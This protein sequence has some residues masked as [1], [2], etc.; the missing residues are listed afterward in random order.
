MPKMH[1]RRRSF[2]IFLALLAAGATAFVW[3]RM[4]PLDVEVAQP[5]HG[6]AIDA[7]YATGIVEP[8]IAVPIVPRVAGRMVERLV[9]EGMRVRKG[10]VLARLEAPDLGAAQDELDARARFAHRALE[11]AATL[12]E[13]GLGSVAAHDQAFAD[14]QAAD[15]AAAR[16]RELMGFMTLMA[17]ADGTIM[18]RDGEVGQ[19]IAINQPIFQLATDAP[20][21]ITADVDEE[22]IADVAVGLPV[23]IHAD[24]FPDAVFDGKVAEVTPMGDPATRS[25]RVRIHFGSETPLRVG[26]TTETNIVVRHHESALLVPSS[27]LIGGHVWVVHGGRLERRAVRVGIEGEKG[28]EI[29]AGLGEHEVIVARPPEGLAAS[30]RVRARPAATSVQGKTAR[31]GRP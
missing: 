21:R 7:V 18:R 6:S 5:R 20:L 31:L 14:A 15:A 4:R 24:A 2:L 19:Y 8:T 25:Y 11:R 1:T 26:M 30:Q 10:Q 16:N 22:N 9:D 13:R 12:L 3:W 29:L 28:T 17:P 27:A 23:V